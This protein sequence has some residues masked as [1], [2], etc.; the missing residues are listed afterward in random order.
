MTTF[1]FPNMLF[2]TIIILIPDCW[3]ALTY[4]SIGLLL[5]YA[6]NVFEILN[7]IILLLG[8]K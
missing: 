1:A 7:Q 8:Y 5:C 2:F 6:S 3:P 4:K